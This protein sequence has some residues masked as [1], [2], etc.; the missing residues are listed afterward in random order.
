MLNSPYFKKHLPFI[1][2]TLLLMVVSLLDRLIPEGMF[3]DGTLYA[4]IARNL[5]IG[6]GSFWAPYVSHGTLFFE[7]PPLMFA[8]ESFFFRIFGDHLYT[9][10]IYS[11]ITWVI[12][13]LLIV[14]LWTK[15][16]TDENYRY[17]FWLPLLLWCCIPTT[18]WSYPNNM[19]ECTMGIFDLAAV[20]I[21]YR[22]AET[23]KNKVLYLLVAA[24]L[25]LFAALSKGPVGLFP[26]AVPAIHWLAFKKNTLGNVFLS[27]ITLFALVATAY[28]L[29][30]QFDAPRYNISM[31]LDNQLFSALSG[32]REKVDSSLGHF[33]LL[34][35]MLAEFAAPLVLCILIVLA[36]I[37]LKLKSD[38]SLS[39]RTRIAIFF[40]LIGLSASLP[41][42]VSIK[43]RSFYLVPSLPYYV[44]SFALFTYPYL[45]ALIKRYTLP[46]RIYLFFKIALIVAALAGV[47]YLLKNVGTAG[48]EQELVHDIKIIS[49]I[50]PEADT[51]GICP[52]MIKDFPFLAY[53]ERYHQIF[54]I[55]H[56][57]KTANR[58]I[59]NNTMCSTQFTDSILQAG[60]KKQETGTWRYIVYQK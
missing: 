60:F 33:A 13:A 55:Q 25:I 26:L 16:S 23:N 28:M 22:L 39:K 6:K 2:I 34:S 35:F 1:C 42:M 15:N 11:F 24:F 54:V 27:S 36:S 32:S 4:A 40:L 8:I 57:N 31:Y 44:I 46:V 29:L 45:T 7:H 49:S 47:P 52:D 38:N 10:K 20:L 56:K 48:R 37:L 41:V 59:L 51:V 3:F 12:T 53:A 19:L 21:L 50:I 9:E 17:S 14:K 43:Q 5:A 18:L 30:W 58:L